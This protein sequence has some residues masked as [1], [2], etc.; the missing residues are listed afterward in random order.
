[1]IHDSAQQFAGLPAS[2]VT[3]VSGNTLL[4]RNFRVLEGRV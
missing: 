3:K 4:G 2:G 1:M